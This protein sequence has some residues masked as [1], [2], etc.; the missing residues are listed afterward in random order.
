MT[1]L[2]I[3]SRR[4][5]AKQLVDIVDKDVDG[6]ISVR[7]LQDDL[8]DNDLKIFISQFDGKRW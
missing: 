1:D 6:Y 7:K 3:S 8:R 4:K 5:V 2:V